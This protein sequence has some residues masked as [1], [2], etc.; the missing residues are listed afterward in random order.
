MSTVAFSWS[1]GL[2]LGDDPVSHMGGRKPVMGAVT[3]AP[4]VNRKLESG[5]GAGS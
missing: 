3:T 4:Q 5:A 1:P 2:E